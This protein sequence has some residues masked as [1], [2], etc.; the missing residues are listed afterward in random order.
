MDTYKVQAR[1]PGTGARWCGTVALLALPVQVA[2]GA[3]L[4]GNASHATQMLYAGLS[5]ALLVAAG[6]A[7]LRMRRQRADAA[8]HLAEATR[9][10]GRR[11]FARLPQ[12]VTSAA[13][14]EFAPV[15]QAC[16]HAAAQLRRRFARLEAALEMD[17]W[18]LT[19]NVPEAMLRGA[20]PLAAG[21]LQSRSV[22]VALLDA[23]DPARA[24]CHDFLV[25]GGPLMDGPRE[26]ELDGH[27]LAA[28]C[29]EGGA[30]DLAAVGVDARAFF[31][32]LADSGAR[33]FRACPL[34][35]GEHVIGFLCVGYRM[36][37]HDQEDELFDASAVAERLSIAFERIAGERALLGGVAPVPERSPLES[38][39]HRALRQDEFALAYQPIVRARSRE[40]CAVEALVRWHESATGTER[41]AGEFIPVAEESGLIVDL[42][43]W[44]LHAAC[45]QFAEWRRE[46]VELDYIS[47]N[48]SAHQLRH[49]GL[50][51]SV[52][53][54]LHR[55]G[56]VPAQLQLEFKESLLEEGPQAMA[57][58]RELAQLGVRLALDD[59][60][61]GQSSLAALRELP[62]SA[63]K[64]DRACIAG[65]D[66]SDQVRSLV[67]A[68]A[69]MGAA[70][71]KQ[72]IAEGVER[73][74]QVRFLEEAGCDA[75]QGFLFA[76]PCEPAG[77]VD[78]SR[79]QQ[80]VRILVA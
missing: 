71:G 41:L 74:E 48:V 3:L 17:R 14:P 1:E 40:L 4:L 57:L 24:R 2:F 79:R 38:G 27:L 7:C 5:S 39:L 68:V 8:G 28:A 53:S 21:I 45:A 50:M 59:Y 25:E 42:G 33:A 35:V 54:T 20:L 13:G 31:T 55:H 23:T 12:L 9:R 69:G 22:S 65:L 76:E 61:D 49:S 64:I 47:V 78:F 37:M 34:R 77:I 10:L 11:D 70:T 6:A 19:V 62:V 16:L 73:I 56:M 43:E 30:I 15:G 36:E 80:Q 67:R 18:L 44:V 60:G 66:G 58:A 75:M 32:P 26:L 52:V 46:G 51:A 72:V 29:S 63:L